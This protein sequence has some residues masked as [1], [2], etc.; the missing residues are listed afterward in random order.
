VRIPFKTWWFEAAFVAIALGAITLF[1][2]GRW[3]EW[4]GTAA[5]LVSFC[6]Q[7]VADRMREAAE[8]DARQGRGAAAACHRFERH[9]YVAK[10][11]LWFGYFLAHR[12]WAALGVAVLFGV[13]PLWRR[14]WRH[15]FPLERSPS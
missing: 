9:Y 13:Y 6:Y 1:T 10:E 7:Q 2:G 5:G 15:F 11:L 8:L 14:A 12:S 4:V 3:V